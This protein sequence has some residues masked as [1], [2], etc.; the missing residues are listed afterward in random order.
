LP[1][2]IVAAVSRRMNELDPQAD[3]QI[4]LACPECH[5]QWQTPLDPISYFWSEIQEWGHRILRDVHAL[6]SA[7]GWREVDVLALSAWR[8]QAYLELIGA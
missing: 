1:E 7:Y 4:A 8:R 5:H 2:A 6:A 3:T